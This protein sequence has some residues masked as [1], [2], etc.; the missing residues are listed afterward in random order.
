MLAPLQPPQHI[1]NFKRI[2]M[3]EIVTSVRQEQTRQYDPAVIV[4]LSP[5]AL[6]LLQG[7][8]IEG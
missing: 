3:E 7:N 5:E 1:Q 6:F 2:Y 8:I 4:D